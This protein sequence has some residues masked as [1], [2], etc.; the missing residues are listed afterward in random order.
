MEKSF[1][2]SA[3]IATLQQ[4]C[5]FIVIGCP[6]KTTGNP[7][8]CMLNSLAVTVPAGHVWQMNPMACRGHDY[9]LFQ[10]F[11]C[12]SVMDV[13]SAAS[14]PTLNSIFNNVNVYYLV[15]FA[16]FSQCTTSYF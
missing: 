7:V 1:L 14:S 5:F 15:V 9:F 8:Y 6:W 10:Y 13:T 16:V 2:L 11:I 3:D 12:Q 4:S